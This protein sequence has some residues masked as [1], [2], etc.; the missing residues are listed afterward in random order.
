LGFGFYSCVALNFATIFASISSSNFGSS[1]PYFS[2]YA[3]VLLLQ[4][5]L[6]NLYLLLFITH[7]LPFLQACLVILSMSSHVPCVRSNLQKKLP[8]KHIKG[9]WMLHA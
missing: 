7:Y 4:L 5:L 1:S 8:S 2:T 6:E 3:L 9:C